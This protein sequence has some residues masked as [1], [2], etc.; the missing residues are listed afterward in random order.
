MA[1][2]NRYSLKFD[3]FQNEYL[4]AYVNK[5]TNI[6]NYRMKTYKDAYSIY[7]GSPGIFV[8]N[9]SILDCEIVQEL[10]K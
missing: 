4:S 8:L 9:V 6:G 7:F 10:F 3:W 1:I 5:S 2:S